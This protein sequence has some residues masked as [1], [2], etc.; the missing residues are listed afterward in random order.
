MSWTLYLCV[1][2]PGLFTACICTPLHDEFAVDGLA[3]AISSQ[4]CAACCWSLRC[5]SFLYDAQ[6]WL[7]RRSGAMHMST[8]VLISICVFA[9]SQL[10]ARASRLGQDARICRQ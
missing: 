10:N 8:V 7:H 2:G 6:Y 9:V 1:A 4:K 5:P 3:P